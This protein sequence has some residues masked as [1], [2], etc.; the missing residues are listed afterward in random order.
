VEAAGQHEPA[1]VFGLTALI[2]SNSSPWLAEAFAISAI[3]A[4][5]FLD[6]QFAQN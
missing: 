5:L 2:D 3:L 4:E 1:E 6:R